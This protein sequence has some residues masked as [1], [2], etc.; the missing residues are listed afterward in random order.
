MS[1]YEHLSHPSSMSSSTSDRPKARLI[2]CKSH[3]A[4]HP[5]Q[6][7]KDNISGYLGVVETTGHPIHTDEDGG[8]SNASSSQ[9]QSGGKQLLVSWV[10]DELLEQMDEDDKRGYKNVDARVTG[11]DAAK[12]NDDDGQSSLM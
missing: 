12:G 4:V 7:N 2:Y 10:P 3:V 11:G 8:V 9:S 1:D 6:F 5:T